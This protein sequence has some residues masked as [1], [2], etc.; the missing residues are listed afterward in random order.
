MRQQDASVK[1]LVLSMHDESL[2]A[3]RVLRA[4][5]LGYVNNSEPPEKLLAA[6]R[7]VLA[8][9]IA[10]SPDVSEQMLHRNVGKRALLA[11]PSI[12]ALSDRELQV[13][14][15]IGQGLATREV[16]ESYASARRP[17]TRTARR[18]KLSSG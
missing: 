2:F 17:S 4:G 11:E 13:F 14:E 16:A 9:H 12:K 18:S 1:I 8:G 5:A 10:V 6:M 3:E 7:S 15:C